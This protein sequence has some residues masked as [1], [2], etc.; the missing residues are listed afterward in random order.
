[1]L[2][3]DPLPTQVRLTTYYELFAT[4][5]SSWVSSVDTDH[6]RFPSRKGM[7]KKKIAKKC[8]GNRG[9][10]GTVAAAAAMDFLLINLGLFS[11]HRDE[12][13]VSY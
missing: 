6:F 8:S 4:A 11:I 12:F 10:T 3:G 5:D 13:V 9:S 7:K 1:M 2:L